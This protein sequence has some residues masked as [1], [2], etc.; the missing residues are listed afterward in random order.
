MPTKPTLVTVK[1]IDIQPYR[2]ALWCSIGDGEP[3]ANEICHVAWSKDYKRVLLGLDT[4]NGYAVDAD[5]EI[6]LVPVD[7]YLAD[8]YVAWKLPPRPDVCEHCGAVCEVTNA[9]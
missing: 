9:D 4:H 7:G 2:Y 6:D 5:A 1:A 3:F 8:K